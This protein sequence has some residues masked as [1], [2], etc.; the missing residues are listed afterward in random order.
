MLTCKVFKL[1]TFPSQH[2]ASSHPFPTLDQR[3]FPDAFLTSRSESGVN[4]KWGDRRAGMAGE[5][6][7][8]CLTFPPLLSL[9]GWCHR[10]GPILNLGPPC[11][12]TLYRDFMGNVP[13]GPTCPG[14][15]ICHV[16]REQPRRGDCTTEQ[17]RLV[18][19]PRW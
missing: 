12:Q 18:W 14:A 11:T 6:G 15:G 2:F 1:L 19:R 4:N 5:A 10:Q 13:P 16:S 8:T 7:A 3:R 9:P 17:G